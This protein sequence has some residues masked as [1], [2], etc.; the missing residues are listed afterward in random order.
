MFRGL[1]IIT[2]LHATIT[3]ISGY[4]IA[5]KHLLEKCTTV[6]RTVHYMYHLV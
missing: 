1:Y 4:Y 3:L 5:I 2:G 6:E